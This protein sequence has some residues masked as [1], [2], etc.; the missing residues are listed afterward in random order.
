MTYSVQHGV[1]EPEGSHDAQ[2]SL[3]ETDGEL[4]SLHHTVV[5]AE[6]QETAASRTVASDGSS[7]GQTVA[8]ELEPH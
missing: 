1:F 3:I 8:V 2:E 5:T 6:S 7:S 4:G